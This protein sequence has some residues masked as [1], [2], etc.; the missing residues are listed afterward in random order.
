MTTRAGCYC[1]PPRALLLDGGGELG[2][3]DDRPAEQLTLQILVHMRMRICGHGSVAQHVYGDLWTGLS[4]R[5]RIPVDACECRDAKTALPVGNRFVGVVEVVGS[6]HSND[7]ALTPDNRHD[8]TLQGPPCLI[9]NDSPVVVSAGGSGE[10]ASR[11]EDRY[12]CCRGG[13][14]PTGCG[15]GTSGCEAR[16]HRILTDRRTAPLTAARSGSRC[17]SPRRWSGSRPHSRAPRRRARRTGSRAARDR[18][19]SRC[20]GC[21]S[22][23]SSPGRSR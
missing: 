5:R 17:R 4:H 12:K 3:S 8:R 14:S 16:G 2:H 19:C 9:V 22:A 6:I 20:P 1:R 13:R 11:R 18:R 7:R 10:D 23:R 15:R 21:R